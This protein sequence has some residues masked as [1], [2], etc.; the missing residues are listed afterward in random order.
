MTANLNK[1]M[2]LG[3][4]KLIESHPFTSAAACAF[5]GGLFGLTLG[6]WGAEK[7]TR[8]LTRSLK[9]LQSTEPQEDSRLYTIAINHM[10]KLSNLFKSLKWKLFTTS[11][12]V[13]A[14]MPATCLLNGIQNGCLFLE[15][16][17]PSN[18]SRVL[19]FTAPRLPI[20]IHQAHNFSGNST[21]WAF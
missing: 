4:A 12:M 13:G 1:C 19:F 3:Y 6:M 21:N 8:I 9:Q 5:T 2:T 14:Y 17:L 7:L 18:A 11:L 20:E 16:P 10:E 15:A